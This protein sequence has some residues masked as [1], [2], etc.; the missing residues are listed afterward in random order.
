MLIIELIKNAA[1]LVAL[2]VLFQ[3]T[4]SRKRRNQI[5]HK[6]LFGLLLGLVGVAVMMTPLTYGDGIF[7]DGRTILLF[8]GGVIGGPLV[9]TLSALCMG[10]YRVWL[11][12]AGMWV[13]L[14]TIVMSAFIGTIYYFYRLRIGGVLS[15]L[16][17]WF[18]GLVVH[19]LMLM[20]FL[21]L[22]DGVG[23]QVVQEVG[24]TVLLV[25]PLG[26]ALVCLLFQDYEAQEQAKLDLHRL[27]YYD[28]LTGLPNRQYLVERLQEKMIV[29]TGQAQFGAL[30]LLHFDRFA[31]VNDAR[32]HGFGDQ[33][34]RQAA[35]RMQSALGD[36]VLLARISGSDFLV[37]PSALF[38]T[39]ALAVEGTSQVLT[40]LQAI[41]TTP[42]EIDD[43]RVSVFVSIGVTYFPVSDTDTAADVLRRADTAM[44]RAKASGGNR[45]VVYEQ[46]MST[47]VERQF[48]LERELRLAIPTG[49]LRV[50]LQSQVDTAGKLFGAEALVRWQHP[51]L[52]L[53]L[54]GSFI[55]L[56]EETDLI[57]D[58]GVWMLRE[59]C[60]LTVQDGFPH[61]P[62]FRVSVN[63][64]PRH[65]HQ[66][67]FV[68]S[69]LSIL[70]QTGADPSRLTFEVTESLLIHDVDDVVKKMRM[71]SD[72]GIHFSLD[73]FGTGY[74]SLTYVKDLPIHE[75]KID[76]S[77]VHEAPVSADSAALVESILAVARH[78]KL[79]V[80]AEGVETIEQA[81]FL[82]TRGRVVYQG[83]LYGR[84][85]SA[86][87]WLGALVQAN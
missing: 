45:C 34:L 82:R 10:A 35:N 26:S 11:G 81:D 42:F 28:A 39:R 32:G 4:V 69:V 54:P 18:G 23:F 31:R 16:Q 17:A 71:L 48:H 7:F 29:T 43:I 56:A 41:V 57:A 72:L 70:A 14:F 86:D 67:G 38:D 6:I 50:Y 77:F 47:V 15:T 21:L 8:V 52:G 27:A 2:V 36:D 9:A 19:L 24:P 5:S 30:V 62:E 85:Q 33:L 12:G 13:G 59:V 1:L 20:I 75:L 60:L 46:A 49:Q 25:Y 73:D 79:I 74:A 64:S 78:M 40:A 63:I 55:P 80:V 87:A 58:L 22:P 76:K 37:L 51:E 61:D 68:P 44:H 65:F 3:V 83:Y 66:S 84:P 53:I